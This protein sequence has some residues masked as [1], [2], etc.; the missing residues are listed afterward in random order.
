MEVVG[1]LGR[2][3][4]LIVEDPSY[5]YVAWL[6]HSNDGSGL[7]CLNQYG[8]VEGIEHGRE[9]TLPTLE[10]PDPSPWHHS[11]PSIVLY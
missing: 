7:A 11:T 2:D 1:S 9:D 4:S 5:V 6:P 10:D 8:F 3:I